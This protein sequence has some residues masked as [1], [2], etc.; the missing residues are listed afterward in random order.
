MNSRLKFDREEAPHFNTTS[1]PVPLSTINSSA[2]RILDDSII[3]YD[4]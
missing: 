4:G 3:L 1:T 2:Q